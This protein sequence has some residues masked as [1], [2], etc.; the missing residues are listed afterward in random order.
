MLWKKKKCNFHTLFVI[1]IFI[2][3]KMQLWYPEN[4]ID[5]FWVK[6]SWKCYG[7]GVLAVDKFDFTRKL[8]KKFW[9]KNSWKWIFKIEFLDKKLTFRILCCTQ[10]T[11]NLSFKINYVLFVQFSSL[12]FLSSLGV[13]LRSTKS[14]EWTDS[15]ALFVFKCLIGSDRGPNLSGTGEEAI[16]FFERW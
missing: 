13:F 2:C 9:V 6:N 14:G 7:F 16:W 10:Q 1:F 12:E 15:F 3:S 8:P 5:F 11:F 4:I